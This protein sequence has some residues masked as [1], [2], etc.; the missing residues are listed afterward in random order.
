MV[1]DI[2]ALFLKY[3]LQDWAAV[4]GEIERGNRHA[5]AGAIRDL[6]QTAAAELATGRAAVKAKARAKAKGRSKTTVKPVA[7]THVAD[8]IGEA[9][10]AV[11]EPIRTALHERAIFPTTHDLKALYIAVGIKTPYP[12]RR[13]DAVDDVIHHLDRMSQ[14][15]YEQALQVLASR[16]NEGWKRTSDEYAQ[17]Y[18][19]I[20]EPKPN[21]S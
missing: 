6:S 17:W 2:A 21:R 4:I 19:I 13:D 5:L 12:K 1:R 10:A 9:R 11:L 14:D 20:L 15:R 8:P 16:D 3:N 18:K 7:P